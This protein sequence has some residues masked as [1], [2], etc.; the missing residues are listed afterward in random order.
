MP[1]PLQAASKARITDV[2]KTE[3]ERF[4]ETLANG[5]EILDA[6]ALDG[7]PKVLPGEVA[8]KLHD[9]YG[10]F[11]LDLT[12]DVC[13]ERGVEV[14]EAGFKTAMEKQKAPPAR[15]ASS[16]WTRR[17]NTPARPTSSPATTSCGETAKIGN[18]RRRT[19]AAALKAG[20]NGV[21]VLD[22]TPFYAESGGQV[23]DQGVIT[24]GSA[25]FAVG[26]TSRS[27][28]MCLA[29]TARWKRAR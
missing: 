9:T 16:R 13:R 23:G 10:T 3:E 26:D 24:S 6:L 12:N 18:L 7:G 2:L 27:R 20:Q 5:M 21:V 4:W 14:D 8:F 1:I 29:T 22:T 11:P 17:W 28:P 19:S 25:R 15:L